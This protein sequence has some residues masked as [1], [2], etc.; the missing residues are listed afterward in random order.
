M[1]GREDDECSAVGSSTQLDGL[2]DKGSLM[3]YPAITARIL[4]LES[5]QAHYAHGNIAQL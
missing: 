5:C 3:S 1:E 4:P 2:T